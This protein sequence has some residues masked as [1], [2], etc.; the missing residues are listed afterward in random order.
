MSL[1]FV[2]GSQS[3]LPSYREKLRKGLVVLLVA[4]LLLSNVPDV[5]KLYKDELMYFAPI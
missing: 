1:M 2:S 4:L 3:R 5:E